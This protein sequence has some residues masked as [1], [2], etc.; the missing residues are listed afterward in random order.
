MPSF[1]PFRIERCATFP[2]VARLR[3]LAMVS[4]WPDYDFCQSL[5]AGEC[6]KA[7]R[8]PQRQG[9]CHRH[10]MHPILHPPIKDGGVQKRPGSTV[11][12]SGCRVAQP[13]GHYEER[14]AVHP[15]RIS[16]QY[17][18]TREGL[19]LVWK[20]LPHRGHADFG[21]A[22]PGFLCP[23]LVRRAAQCLDLVTSQGAPARPLITGE[24]VSRQPS[25]R[26]P[27]ATWRCRQ[28]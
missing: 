9:G 20:L 12:G 6:Q 1:A 17:A 8:V 13:I 4:L 28:P 10:G 11:I 5:K 23:P 21:L 26:P 27:W 7:A 25:P 15:G 16:A 2:A 22:G 3:G 18:R 19:Q 14:S 24:V